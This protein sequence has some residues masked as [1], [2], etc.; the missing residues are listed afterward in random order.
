VSLPVRFAAEAAAELDAAA[1]WYHEQRPGLG[2]A[3]IDAV[4]GALRMVSQWPGSGAPVPGMRVDT[5]VRRVPVQG[6]P[7]HLPYTVIDDHVRILAVA[8]D[9]RR[10]RY[11][12]GRGQ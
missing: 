10:P 6:F 11:W 12:T 1:T 3:F 7:Y 9:R 4:E 8:H 2:A 5:D